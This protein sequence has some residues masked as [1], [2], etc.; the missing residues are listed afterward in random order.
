MPVYSVIQ[1]AKYIKSSVDADR[2]LGN[3]YVTGEVSNFSRA[4]SGH[5]YFTLKDGEAQL[6]CV[7]FRDDPG[8]EHL[9]NGAAVTT[10]GRITFYPARGELQ[11]YVDLVQPEGVGELYMQFLRVKATLESEGLFDPARK[12]P[13]P[14]FPRRIAVVTSLAGAVVHDIH[15]VLLRRYPMVELVLIHTPVQGDQAPLGIITALRTAAMEPGLDLVIL[16]RGG[17]ALEEM[18]AYNREDVAR[19]IH[20]CP[21]PIISAV[22]HETDVT[23]ADLVADL[24]APTPSAAAELATPD[25]RVLHQR[26]AQFSRRLNDDVGSRATRQKTAVRHL[27]DRL[28]YLV[29]DLSTHRQRIDELLRAANAVLGREMDGL[30]ERTN[31]RMLQ[32]DS[33]HPGNTLARG[34]ALVDLAADGRAVVLPSDVKT[35]DAVNVRLAEGSFQATVTTKRNHATPRPKRGAKPIPAEQGNLWA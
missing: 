4:S 24:R 11:Y 35:G 33:L 2:V 22:G 27:K 31:A 21:I 34:Y 26:I 30:R 3:L 20:A 23:I 1:V 17:G 18:A 16:A 32:L 15:N 12:R 28:N 25:V 29:P 13:L 14:A 10:H 7:K 5:C 9:A 8:E 6:R 19:A